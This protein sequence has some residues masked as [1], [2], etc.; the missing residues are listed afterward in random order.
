MALFIYLGVRQNIVQA[1]DWVEVTGGVQN[2]T[3]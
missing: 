3:G 1:G 2:I